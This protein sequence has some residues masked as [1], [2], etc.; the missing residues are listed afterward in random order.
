M[1][2]RTIIMT[3]TMTMTMIM[4]T[5]TV[6]VSTEVVGIHVY[7]VRSVDIVVYVGVF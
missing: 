6:P 2:M 3:T 4:T 1:I 5:N 7:A